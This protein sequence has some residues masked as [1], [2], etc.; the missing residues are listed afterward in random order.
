MTMSTKTLR[1]LLGILVAIM[2]ATFGATAN[3]RFV[4]SGF[5]PLFFAGTAV[6]HVDDNCVANDGVHF[7][8]VGNC[9]GV[10]L[11]GTDSPFGLPTVQLAPPTGPFLDFSNFGGSTA[12]ISVAVIDGAVVGINTLPIGFFQAQSPNQGYSDFYY[13]EFVS[14][15]KFAYPESNFDALSTDSSWSHSYNAPELIS[16]TNTVYLFDCPTEYF[17]LF[18]RSKCSVA[19]PATSVTFAQI[20]EPGTLALLLG[21]VGAGWLARRRKHGA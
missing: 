2:A 5:D 4:S 21:G 8:N 1:L 17:A 12:M 16:V 11:M 3:A 18:G 13:I 10:E 19:D 14:V 9:T 20:P 7:A 15:P 6:F